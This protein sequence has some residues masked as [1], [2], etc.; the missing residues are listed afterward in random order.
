[1]APAEGETSVPAHIVLLS[2]GTNTT[3]RTPERGRRRPPSEA[4][5]PVS[6]IAYGTPGRRRR[7]AGP[8]RGRCPVDEETLADAGRG[9][10]R[11]RPTPRESSDELNEVYDD[12][13]SSIGWRI[14]PREVTPYVSAIALVLRPARRRPVPALVRPPALTTPD[15][16]RLP[17]RTEMPTSPPLAR[18]RRAGRTRLRRPGPRP[19]RHAPQPAGT[20]PRRSR[21]RPCRNRS[22]RRRGAPALLPPIVEAPRRPTAEPGRRAAGR[23]CS[24]AGWPGSPE[25]TGS[26][27]DPGS[28][29]HARPTPPRPA[30]GARDRHRGVGGRGRCCRAWCRCAATRGTRLGLRLRPGRARADQRARRRRNDDRVVLQLQ[31]GRQVTADVVGTDAGQRRRRAARPTSATWRPPR[32]GRSSLLR[33]GAARHRDRLAARP[34]RHRHG[35]DRQ[36]RRPAGPPRRR[37]HASR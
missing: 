31:G 29:D 14:E 1:M 15:L 28:T 4:G 33:I 25:P 26:G 35:R 16:P 19:P 12:I 20:C 3:G 24:S 34:E 27:P 18:A 23:P 8:A 30:A 6:T 22:S 7:G 36:R 32:S 10:R 17:E 5:V 11:A 37:Q 9:H 13:Q 2:D 21:R